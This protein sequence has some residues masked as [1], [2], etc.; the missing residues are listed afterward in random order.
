[1]IDCV[2]IANAR[3]FSQNLITAQ[4]RLRYREVIAKEKWNNIYVQDDMEFD[5][6]D[7][8]ATEYLV[9]RDRQDHVVGVTRLYPTTIPFMLQEAFPYL[10]AKPFPSG[11]D[12]LEA[13]RLVL[14]RD[15]L[16]KKSRRPIIDQLI[17]AYLERGLDRGI[18]AYVGFM[19]PKI[20][21]STFLRC[22]WDINWLG[23]PALIPQTGDTVRAALMPVNKTIESKI[24]KTTAIFHK[25]INYGDSPERALSS[26][27][28]LSQTILNNTS[29]AA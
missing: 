28:T 21:T 22:G 18:N 8:P 27:A 1:M 29:H 19:L 26:P 7:N 3:G 17:L 24:R 11:T 15:R 16:D 9:A 14:D 25:V 6:Y 20:W 4:H 10:S 2:S 23:P 5:R 12:I 13:S